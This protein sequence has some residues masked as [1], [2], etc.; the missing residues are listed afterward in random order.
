[1]VKNDSSALAFHYLR[2]SA[3]IL[4]W[5][6]DPVPALHIKPENMTVSET[7]KCIYTCQLGLPQVLLK[8]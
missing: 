6:I 7:L 3:V 1:M 8:P 4:T 2:H 5:K